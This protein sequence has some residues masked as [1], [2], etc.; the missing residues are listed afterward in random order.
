MVELLGYGPPGLGV[1]YPIK[2][3][4]YLK[5]PHRGPN[6]RDWI[7]V[8]SQRARLDNLDGYSIVAQPFTFTR[9]FPTDS[10][11]G[12]LLDLTDLLKDYMLEE[13]NRTKIDA[14]LVTNPTMER[15]IDKDSVMF[16][17]ILTYLS[18]NELTK[19]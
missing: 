1:Y 7:K 2:L 5:H 19:K 14:V 16:S 9:D 8:V 15:R 17:A 3:E 12:L 6:D 18:K 4:V 11:Q 13:V 10:A